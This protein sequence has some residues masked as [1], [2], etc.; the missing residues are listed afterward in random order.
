MSERQKPLWEREHGPEY[1]VPSFVSDV[2][3]D[4]SWHN[5]VCPRFRFYADLCDYEDGLTDVCNVWVDHPD[6]SL[7]D[8][9]GGTRFFVTDDNGDVEY[10]LFE[11][12]AAFRSWFKA[13]Y[14]GKVC[15]CCAGEV[16][17][18]TGVDVDSKN[19]A[20][21]SYCDDCNGNPTD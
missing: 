5:D 6:P 13:H 4:D 9:I 11:D 3:V 15:Y 8:V 12:E 18:G 19:G 20:P 16:P 14:L 21:M 2:C 10:G 1:V 7:R 17:L